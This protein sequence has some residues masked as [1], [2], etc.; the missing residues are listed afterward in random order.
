MQWKA[1]EGLYIEKYH[2]ALYIFKGSVDND[3]RK[4]VR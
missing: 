3:Q 4:Q 1:M 2:G